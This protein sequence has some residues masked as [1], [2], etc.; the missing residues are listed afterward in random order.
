MRRSGRSRASR[1]APRAY[2]WMREGSYVRRCTARKAR[3]GACCWR[4]GGA[5]RF[6]PHAA[7]A[8]AAFLRPG[9]PVILRGDAF[10]TDHGTVLA[11]HAIG[12]SAADLRPLD[13]G[14]PP[15]R[16]GDKPGGKHRPPRHGLMPASHT[17][18]ITAPAEFDPGAGCTTHPASTGGGDGPPRHPARVKLARRTPASRPDGA[19]SLVNGGIPAY[20]CAAPSQKPGSNAD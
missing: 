3:C 15:K 5:G 1:T 13:T 6:P 19:F 10:V 18:T 2:P 16:H 20:V 9:T 8:A 17:R 4:T 12:R 7:E 14:K 11:V